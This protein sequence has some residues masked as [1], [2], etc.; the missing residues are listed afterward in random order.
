MGTPEYISPEQIQG[1]R[2]DERSDVYALGVML[3]EMI[4]GKTPF[5]NP[6]PFATMNGQLVH[7]PVPPM[8]VEPAVSS[9]LQEAVYRA[10]ERD[11]RDRYLSAAEFAWDLEHQD[12]VQ[13]T[14]R[15]GPRDWTRLFRAMRFSRLCNT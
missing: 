4:T 15:S 5:H 13:I 2:G 14:D 6:N 8:E 10:L 3:Y 11:P 1:K 7:N 12:Q 9:Q